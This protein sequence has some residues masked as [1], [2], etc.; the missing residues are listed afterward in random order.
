MARRGWLRIDGRRISPPSGTAST[1]IAVTTDTALE[2]S[3]TR[4]RTEA[5]VGGRSIPI[6]EAAGETLP[7][8]GP[9]SPKRKDAASA[10]CNAVSV[11]A[12]H[13][14]RGCHAAWNWPKVAR[15][16]VVVRRARRLQLG[17]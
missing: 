6:I 16:T 2:A 12:I 8:G 11:R 9:L 15:W 3:R 7:L 5:Q 10:R 1:R 14:K 13:Q 4:M 17:S